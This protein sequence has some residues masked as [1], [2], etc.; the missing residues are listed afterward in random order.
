[1]LDPLSIELVK[2]ADPQLPIGLATG[3]DVGDDHQDSVPNGDEGPLF[4]APRGDAPVLRGQVGIL[5]P[6]GRV[7]I[8]GPTGRVGDLDQHLAQ[9]RIARA[10]LA[11][12]AF[13]LT[14]GVAPHIPAQEARCLASWKR[15][16]SLPS[17]ASRTSAARTLMPGTG[18]DPVSWRP[19]H[20][21][22][23]PR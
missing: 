2:I 7:G 20:L 16:R 12:Q 22:V 10:G 5:G 14:F 23:T 4:A 9:R 21:G 15:L 11:A 17:S 1:M 18:L 19:E 13:T 3:Q 6:T 8:L